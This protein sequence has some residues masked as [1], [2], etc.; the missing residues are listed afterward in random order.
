MTAERGVALVTGAARRV[1]R[2]IAHQL[3]GAGYD[4]A[5]HYH[6]S[7]DDAD[8]TVQMVRALGRR[9][10]SFRADFSESAAAGQ[11]VAQVRSR[12]GRLDALVNN[13][14]IFEPDPAGDFDPA[15]WTRVLQINAIAP[16]QLIAAAADAL[17]ASGTGAVVN[18]CDIAADRPWKRFAAYCASKA[19][20]V[21]L[22]RAFARR[23]APDVRVN[24]VSPGIAEF[25]DDFDDETRKRLVAR[26]PLGRAGTPDDI[27]A[28]VRFLLTDGA[29]VTG[30]IIVVDG[31]R[32]IA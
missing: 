9:A 7:P 13:A 22:T 6:R 10:D 28:A 16:A 31:G 20:L 18:L 14:A 23:L 8:Q 11:L 4:V 29:Y 27:A 32:S 30:Q 12:Y 17:A 19:A 2:A 26:V 15:H 3:A 21:N 5:V 1:G 24:G 25:P